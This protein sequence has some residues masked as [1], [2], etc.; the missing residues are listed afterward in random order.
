MSPPPEFIEFDRD[1][2]KIEELIRFVIQFRSFGANTP[3]PCDGLSSAFEHAAQDLHRVSAEVRTDLP[4]LVGSLLLYACGRFE[5]FVGELVRT[6]ADNCV[7]KAESYAALSQVIRKSLR[8]QLLAVLGKPGKYEYLGLSDRQLAITL[9]KLVVADAGEAPSDIPTQ[10]LSLTDTNMNHVTLKSVFARVGVNDVWSDI[11]K[12]APL[13][14][15]FQ[16]AAEGDCRKAAT[17]FLDELMKLRNSI[18]HPIGSPY[19][20]SPETA[21]E[22]CLSLR[23]LSRAISDVA[24]LPR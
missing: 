20:P 15:H 14:T 2:A 10:I 24:Y 4:I 5:Y 13:R 22:H 8:E 9:S 21:L 18:A 17:S 12:Q 6:L 7:T 16:T 11:S 1:L 19:F 3:A 23:E